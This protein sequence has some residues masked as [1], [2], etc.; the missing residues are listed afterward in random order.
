MAALDQ[1]WARALLERHGQG[2]DPL[3]EVHGWSNR[4]W[5]AP[6]AVVRVSEGRFRDSFGHEARVLARLAGQ[7]PAPHVLAHGAEGR[8]QWL[9]LRRVPGD[10]LMLA[11]SGMS[12]S[13][14]EA[15][16]VALGE[17][18]NQLHAVRSADDLTNPW[19]D[20]AVTVEGKAGDAY[21]A[22]PSR[23]DVVLGSLRRG[24]LLEPAMLDRA[25]RWLHERWPLFEGDTPCLVHG[26]AHFNNVMWDREAGLTLIDFEVATHL[27]RDRDLEV[28]VDMM[29][30]PAEYAGPGQTAL[31]DSA[32]FRDILAV[33]EDA[34]PTLFAF[35]DRAERMRV[36]F[37]MRALLQ[38]HHFPAGSGRDPRPRL[39][40]LMDGSFGLPL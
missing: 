4:V 17:A 14:R 7:V 35:A 29:L 28:L 38:C 10:P 12:G 39:R 26:D 1:R 37:V 30:H 22:R 2:A 24:E 27:A 8:Q 21:R 40:A 32:A 3:R 19:L 23:F 20:D 18:F 36:Y 15:A 31:P 34:A 33:L 16:V 25:A 11:W 13:E 9:L 5:I 6:E